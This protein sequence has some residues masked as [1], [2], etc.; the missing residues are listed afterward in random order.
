MRR[1]A[2][3]VVAFALAAALAGTARA[4]T[5]ADGTLVMDDG[6]TFGTTLYMPDGTP[7][8]TGWPAIMMLHG[9]G[10]NRIGMNALAESWYVPRGYAVFTYDARGH[11]Q[12]GGVVTID[13]PREIADVRAA[14]DYLAAQPGIDRSHIGVWGISY[15]G[16]AAWL[17]A[18]AGVPFAAIQTFE[19]W[20]DL[21]AALIPNDLSKSGAV[22]GFLSEISPAAISPLIAGIK[23]DLLQSTNLPALKAL[24]TE[25]SS[26]SRIGTLSTPA[27]MYQG[28][29]DF[30]FDMGQMTRTFAQLKGPKRLYLGNLGHSPSTFPS[31][32]TS[33]FLTESQL[34][35]DRF[36]K[37]QPNGI[38]TRPKVEVA[39]TP[40]KGKAVSYPG[41][42]PTKTITLTFSGQA[43]I[44]QSGKVVRTVPLPKTLLEQFGAPRVQVTV[45][46]TSQFP[47]L[48][49][50]LSAL[51]PRGEV[52]LSEGGIQ[53]TYSSTAK[54]VTFRLDSD[55]T[56]IPARSKLRITLASNSTAQNPQNLLYLQ[57]PLPDGSKL[58]IGKVRVDLPVLKTPISK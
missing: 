54:T 18:V 23:G 43:T 15:G 22:F 53:T 39:P 27:A 31:D 6:V 35:Y 5:K 36:L 10:G 24:S 55:S 56:P 14:F 20:T 25:R 26:L 38:D 58:T 33:Y 12:S 13:G 46:T 17:S 40:F 32:D 34:W 3:L 7:P 45:S 11:G 41:L 44:D 1:L 52:I 2:T 28:K 19:T 30:A 37:N 29:R 57:T 4:F 47:H 42:P 50:V 8:S 51:T 9:L 21:Y 16:G 48:V 49:A